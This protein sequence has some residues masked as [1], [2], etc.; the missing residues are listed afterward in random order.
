MM[1]YGRFEQQKLKSFSDFHKKFG[2]RFPFGQGAPISNENDH[3]CRNFQNP[4]KPTLCHFRLKFPI[5][6][7]HINAGSRRR[8]SF[9]EGFPSVVVP[10]IIIIAPW[11]QSRHTPRFANSSSCY[12]ISYNF[13]HEGSNFILILVTISS[14][15]EHLQFAKEGVYE[16]CGVPI[17]QI[18]IDLNSSLIFSPRR[19]MKRQSNT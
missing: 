1:E 10:G 5:L 13:I 15:K 17:L 19:W 4:Y 6:F 11:C 16:G 9:F 12:C 8:V 2:R 18:H 14:I 3:Q 7:L